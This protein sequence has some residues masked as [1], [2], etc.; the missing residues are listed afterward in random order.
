M[1]SV[2][3]HLNYLC[4]HKCVRCA[5]TRGCMV[6]NRLH[7]LRVKHMCKFSQNRIHKPYVTVYLVISLPKYRIHTP[8]LYGSG[9]PYAYLLFEHH[10]RT[11]IHTQPFSAYLDP[12]TTFFRVPGS[13]HNLISR[14]WIHTQPLNTT[15]V[16]GSTRNLTH[17]RDARTQRPFY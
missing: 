5:L 8:Y 2:A 10:M 12:H 6:S 14:T 13:T 1:T 9:Q 3:V 11:W 17:R 7:G 15:C 4:M 16:P